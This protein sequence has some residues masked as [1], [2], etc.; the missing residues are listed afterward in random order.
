[1]NRKSKYFK[2]LAVLLCTT[3]LYSCTNK[4]TTPK[5][6]D[7]QSNAAEQSNLSVAGD[8]EISSVISEL[9]TYDNDEYYVDWENQNPNYIELKGTD[10][11]LTGLGAE[12]KDG[13]ITITK[14]GIYV[15]SGI[16]DNG[17]I[18]I[19]EEDKGIVRLVLNGAEIN[20]FDNA[21]IYVKNA[22]KTIITLQDGTENVISDGEEYVFSDASTDE[23][24][25]AIFSKDD[26]IINGTG[27]LIV[28]G[29]YNNGITSK[30]DLKVV[31]GNIQIYS[32][33][34]GLMGRDMVAIKEGNIIIEAVGDGIKSTNDTDTSKGFIA[35]EA[36]TFDIKAGSDGIQAETSVLITDGTFTISSG[37]GSGNSSKKISG[38]RQKPWGDASNN[39]ITTT[40][41][42]ESES[43]KAIK[44]A[45]EI[46]IGGGNFNI[47]SSDDAIHSNNSVTIIGGDIFI[48]SGDDGIHADSSIIIKGGKINITKSYEGIESAVI[49]VSDGEI[50][51]TASD[52]GINVAG[53][54]DGSSLQGR[55]GQNNFSASGNYKL[56]INGGYI[57]V[58]ASGDGLD[59][60]GSIY[61]TDGTVIVNG[62]TTNGNGALDYDGTFEMSGGL[63]VAAGSAGMAQ[64]PSDQSSQY[65]IIMNYSQT[66]PAGTVAHLED[67][68]GNTI[69]TFSP[70]KNYQ[71]LV[72]SSPE[73]KKD[74][75]YTLYTG[76]TSTGSGADGLYTDGKYEG[77]TKIVDFTISNVVT[78]LSEAGVTTAKS[79]QPG[80]PNGGGGFGGDQNRPQRGMAPMDTN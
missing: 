16:L 77:G 3:L 1:M 44:A 56:N 40:D 37:G 9:V 43:A 24:N 13:K 39:T 46:V 5:N 35:V 50:H 20:C 73:L 78:W 29:N 45:A 51:V 8:K 4:S 41:E 75:T 69:V 2:L 33:D 32:A 48:A 70:E 74:M 30:D 72:I 53:G 12:M 55:H 76:G 71:S 58:D 42:T 80:G 67:S 60:N 11:N 6:T 14:A 10:A 62:P 66:Q 61:M 68:N 28:R 18:V 63:L 17:Q 31:G 7:P 38:N 19:D 54:N 26:L 59:A 79:A 65:S 15:I 57:V 47:D 49:T 25:A 52:D 22:G 36:G 34:D 64:A 27:K 21:P 23:P